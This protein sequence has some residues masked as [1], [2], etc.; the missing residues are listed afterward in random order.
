MSLTLG[1]CAFVAVT[2][3]ADASSSYFT[4][5][6]PTSED[7]LAKD[8]SGTPHSLD[9]RV[10]YYRL[11]NDS[12][13][14]VSPWH[15]VDLFPGRE[16][17]SAAA[18]A[19][20][21]AATSGDADGKTKKKKDKKR[22]KEKCPSPG[23]T[24]PVDVNASRV[25]HT[26]VENPSGTH[27]KNELNTKQPGNPVRADVTTVLSSETGQPL[28]DRVRYY[29]YSPVPGHYG[30]LPRTWYEF[31]FSGGGSLTHRPSHSPTIPTIHPSL[32]FL[33][34]CFL[35]RMHLRRRS[36]DGLRLRPW[37]RWFSL[38]HE[39]TCESRV[40]GRRAACTR[41]L[42]PFHAHA[43]IHLWTSNE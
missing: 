31:S 29:G 30:S 14:A 20:A 24:Q 12:V 23:S 33:F 16:A 35:H 8:I 39:F 21:R 22:R 15:D 7:V 25:I 9:F 27:A 17:A 38:Y 36:L 6:E 40:M 37:L 11:V 2:S 42:S 1:L 32:S 5:L 34:F 4:V 28:Y 26:V 41:A 10:G 13:A 43:R 18:S 19:I 3:A